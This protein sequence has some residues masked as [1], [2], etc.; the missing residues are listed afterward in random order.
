MFQKAIELIENSSY[1]SLITHLNVDADSYASAVALLLFLEKRLQKKVKIINKEGIPRN[2]QKLYPQEKVKSE[3]PFDSD[4]LIFVDCANPE[5]AGIRKTEVKA[6]TITIDHHIPRDRFADVELVGPT[7]VSTA[8]LVYKLLSFTEKKID[9]DV[10]QALFCAI[11]SDSQFFSLGRSDEEC[12][13]IA[14]ELIGLGASA[15]AADMI[16]NK[17]DSLAKFRLKNLALSSTDLALEGALAFT[18]ITSTICK[19]SGASRSDTEGFVDIPLSIEC[20]EA[21]VMLTEMQ[22]Y[23]KVSLRSKNI[24]VSK[25]AESFKGGGHKKAAGCK[26]YSKDINEAKKIITEKVREAL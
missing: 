8:I 17:S 16:L 6:R 23:Y 15:E 21:S 24:D 9:K 22:G 4:L 2:L 19:Q 26:I 20:V 11:A 7:L 1:I 5:R 13:L 14:S 18:C 3:V 10:A 25:I 12:Y